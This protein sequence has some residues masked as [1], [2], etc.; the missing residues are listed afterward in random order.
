[1]TTCVTVRRVWPQLRSASIAVACTAAFSAPLQAQTQGQAEA[2]VRVTAGVLGARSVPAPDTTLTLRAGD[3][4]L[5][6]ELRVPTGAGPHPVAI[7]IHGGCWVT[8]FADARYMR[9]LAE[10]LRQAGFAT[11]TIAYRRA[12]E[13]GG[14]WPGTFLDVA[15]MTAR[16]RGLAPRY[17]LDLQRVIASGHSAGAHLA[18][19]LVAQGKLPA[20]S[21]A[22][23]DATAMPIGAVVALDGPADLPAANAG[24]TRICGGAVLEQLLASTP[25]SAPERWRNASPSEFLPLGVPQA[26]VRGS[27]DARLPGFGSEAGALPAYDRRARAAGDSTWV[28]TADSTSHFTMLDPD[29]PAFAVTLQAFR[30]ALAAMRRRPN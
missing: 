15:A 12:D 6:A 11:W 30:N 5:T 10:G 17:R 25:A 4:D 28:V 29:Q 1:M 22:G 18:L 8:R 20:G 26:L 24:I 9:P 19:W 16:V 23:A 3:H 21:G 13:A 2:P 27:L 14:G 7:V